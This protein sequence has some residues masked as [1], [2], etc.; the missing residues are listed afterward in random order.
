MPKF[1]EKSLV[2]DYFDKALQARGWKSVSADNLERE[3]LEEPLLTANLIRALKKLNADLAIGDEEI[4]QALNQLKLKISG[5]EGAK[6][7]LNYFKQG[8]PVKFEKERVV[9][10][11][12]LFDYDEDKVLNNE[13]II[14]TSSD[15]S[16]GEESNKKRHH[17]LRKWHTPCQY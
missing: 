1:D 5:V 15:S 3:S 12:R 16:N 11:V 4:K 9:H 10:Y 8:I 6:Q 17:P 2:E 7:I 13:F 14:L